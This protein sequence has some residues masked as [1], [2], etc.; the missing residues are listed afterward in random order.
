MYRIAGVDPEHEQTWQR[1]ARALIAFSA[2]AL[3]LSY[4]I[5]RLQ[6]VLPFN[7]QHL[8]GVTPV[9]AVLAVLSG[10]GLAATG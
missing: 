6:G 5:F 7:P 4:A 10:G 2:V 8:P 3:G 1:Y 9:L